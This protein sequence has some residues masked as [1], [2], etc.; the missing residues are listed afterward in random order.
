[1]RGIARALHHRD[2]DRAVDDDVGHRAARDGAV[3]ARRHHRHLGGS[4]AVAAHHRHR[5]PGQ[6][7]VAAHG[8]QRL[9]EEDVRDHDA[10]GDAERDPEDAARVEVEIDGDPAPARALRVERP[11]QEPAELR[12]QHARER[13]PHERP[14]GDPARRL[15]H[16]DD[17]ERRRDEP[18]PGQARERVRHRGIEGRDVETD[19][20]RGRGGDPVVPGH[21]ILGGR[22]IGLHDDEHPGEA[23]PHEQPEILL[24]EQRDRQVIL[25]P[26]R[27]ER[28]GHGDPDEH[29][30]LD[31]AR[32][33]AEAAELR[34][35]FGHWRRRRPRPASATGS[36]RAAFVESD[37]SPTSRRCAPCRSGPRPDGTGSRRPDRPR[38]PASTP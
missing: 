27:Q 11:G 18:V 16:H 13:D 37:P 7:R 19:A 10:G 8:G 30:A 26:E 24:V 22:G 6:E 3:E 28:A 34:E 14:A 20:E 15:E 12:V 5:E 2:R 17:R 9:A 21:V 1:M 25:Q 36:P 4:A 29:H 38:G 31:D 23:E 33:A 35:D 32:G